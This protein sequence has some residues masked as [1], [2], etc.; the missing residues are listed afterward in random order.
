M[1]RRLLPMRASLLWPRL[2]L[3]RRICGHARRGHASR[4]RVQQRSHERGVA[5]LARE[6]QRCEGGDVALA[7]FVDVER[8]RRVRRSVRAFEHGERQRLVA[9]RR[10]EPSGSASGSADDEAMLRS[11]ARPNVEKSAPDLDAE[12]PTPRSACLN[13]Q[14]AA[15]EIGTVSAPVAAAISPDVSSRIPRAP[16]RVRE[17][18]TRRFRPPNPLPPDRRGR[19]PYPPF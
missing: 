9:Q 4:T 5:V 13:P 14:S 8:R 10:P 11:S 6:V 12:S 18:S 1:C 19:I 2:R 17:S 15:R 16:V 7:E 3:R